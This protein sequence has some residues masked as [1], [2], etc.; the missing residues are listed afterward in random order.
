[1]SM[2]LPRFKALIRTI[3]VRTNPFPPFNRLNR[4]PYALAIRRIMRLAE[5][6][7]GIVSV[8]LRHG[9]TR[10]DWE[11]GLSD[12]DFTIVL[13]GDQSA[14][15]EYE[16]VQNFMA[17]YRA[18][19]RWFPMLGEVEILSEKCC[20]AWSRFS[21]RGF[22]A[23]E[24]R[25][26]HGTHTVK[27]AFIKNDT[28]MIKVSLDHACW[29]Y[30]NHI[31]QRFFADGVDAWIEKQALQRLARKMLRYAQVESI[32][33]KQEQIVLPNSAS[34]IV[35][36]VLDILDAQV[37]E[38]PQRPAQE[39]PSPDSFPHLSDQSAHPACHAEKFAELHAYDSII[40]SVILS[41]STSFII[42]RD[43]NPLSTLKDRLEEIRAI[44]RA[45]DIQPRIMTRSVFCYYLQFYRPQVCLNLLNYRHVLFGAD[46]LE[47]I[48][49]PS[50]QSL[51]D[52]LLNQSM[53]VMLAPA[54]HVPPHS[55]R[56]QDQAWTVDAWRGVFLR[57]YFDA[58]MIGSQRPNAQACQLRYPELCREIRQLAENREA[59]DDHA[60][61]VHALLRRS[62]L[63]INEKIARMDSIRLPAARILSANESGDIN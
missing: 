24:W 23:G 13:S 20:S 60:H 43:D 57:L 27:P 10:S 1:M 32:A 18:L 56:I 17:A 4:L 22:E 62:A 61:A 38:V 8:Y 3:V 16:T 42:L 7:P 9:L 50:A 36:Q 39:Q 53:N 30:E 2:F 45:N 47:Q 12:I 6:F 34:A 41:Y 35:L 49:E 5:S 40:L 26:L 52:E 63:E 58:G 28:S 25:L 14:L 11:P 46:L 15:Q 59:G 51:A 44:C 54:R 19:K 37:R 55:S 33:G 31:L 29:I 21:I 48:A